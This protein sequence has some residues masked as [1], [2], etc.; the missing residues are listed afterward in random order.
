MS[1]SDQPV[2]AHFDTQGM[3]AEEGK[4]ELQRGTICFTHT[5]SIFLIVPIQS[6]FIFY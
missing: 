6:A 2:K 3:G 4:W 5:L 1:R